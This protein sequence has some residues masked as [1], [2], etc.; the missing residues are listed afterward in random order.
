VLAT[1]ALIPSIQTR[2][3]FLVILAIGFFAMSARNVLDPD[4]W[5]HLRS[6]QLILQDHAIFHADP[7]S[8][9]RLGQP[10]INHE[11]LTDVFMYRLYAV[12]GYAALIVTFAT[13]TSAALIFVFLRCKATPAIAAVATIL[14]A[15]AS[16]PSWGVRPQ[17]IS[18][19]LA[20]VFFYLLDR[21]NIDRTNTG[22]SKFYW[23]FPVLT[24]LWV[25]LHAGYAIGIAL[26]FVWIVGDLLDA[27]VGSEPWNIIAPRVR[28]LSLTLLCCLAAIPL[29]PYGV[30]MYSYPFATL[31]SNAMQ[32]LIQEWASPDF[33]QAKYCATLLI[34]L[35]T[36]AMLVLSPKKL[37]GQQL[38]LVCGGTLAA[39]LSVRHI[40]LFALIAAPILSQLTQTWLDRKVNLRTSQDAKPSCAATQRTFAHGLIIAV[41]GF[42]AAAQIVHLVRIQ[43][44]RGRQEFP[45]GASQFLSQ[46]SL[47]Q[48]IFNSYNW[49][50]Y[51]I[52]NNY[53]N[54]R[55]FIDGRADVYGDRFLQDFGDSYYLTNAWRKPLRDWNIQTV[56]V[57][58]SAPLAAALG[59]DA[60]WNR[61]YADSN[62]VVYTRTLNN[63]VI[64]VNLLRN[65]IVEN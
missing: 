17:M 30:K 18:F 35:A 61:V 7:Y 33:H 37:S 24:M 29:N 8:F 28:N 43:T 2:R 45:Y 32:N 40:P 51:L 11:W 19:L 42:F 65:H 4:I 58:P 6:G 27:S 59:L 25:N 1:L 55:V 34:I 46:H 49:G 3:L 9:T 57:P 53:P 20:S 38:L 63:P 22:N 21:L 41:L 12:G 64:T 62:A 44:A 54:Y 10:W 60:A 16:A 5:W 15:F 39:L 47:G 48:P 50:G 26:L 13:I 56:I 23:C 14:G 52:W 36:F 31:Y